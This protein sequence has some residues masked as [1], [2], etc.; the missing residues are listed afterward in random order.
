MVME[1]YGGL[2]ATGSNPP[3]Q[4]EGFLK[5]LLKS[6]S[7]IDLSKTAD[8]FAEIPK[9]LAPLRQFDPEITLPSLRM[10][11]PG[12]FTDSPLKA[13][14]APLRQTGLKGSDLIPFGELALYG[15]Q[16]S[17]TEV[18]LSIGSELL[19]EGVGPALK[20]MALPLIGKKVAK[21]EF[22]IGIGGI[23]L[24]GIKDF[25]KSFIKDPGG[26]AADSLQVIPGSERTVLGS[27]TQTGK[28][29]V[30][31]KQ[32][33]PIEGVG[34][35]GQ[36]S[37]EEAFYGL[38]PYYTDPHIPKI[39]PESYT[40]TYTVYNNSNL[41]QP[42]YNVEVT[43]LWDNSDRMQM[44]KMFEN[45]LKT[46]GS[47]EDLITMNQT[48]FF[49]NYRPMIANFNAI[50]PTSNLSLQG[51]APIDY[52]L[53]DSH[54]AW[55][56]LLGPPSHE[57]GVDIMDIGE[58]IAAQTGASHL[59]GDAGS[60]AKYSVEGVRE[61]KGPSLARVSERRAKTMGTITED[62]VFE[63]PIMQSPLK[64][65]ET[66]LMITF[67]KDFLT[68]PNLT[69]EQTNFLTRLSFD[70]AYQSY[71]HTVKTTDLASTHFYEALRELSR[72]LPEGGFSDDFIK[73][74]DSNW[75]DNYETLPGFVSPFDRNL[76]DNIL[77][78]KVT[79]NTFRQTKPSSVEN[80]NN[81]Y[82]AQQKIL[83][84]YPGSYYDPGDGIIKNANGEPLQIT[85]MD[86][87]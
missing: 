2:R 44:Y 73:L 75:L 83:N 65:E 37:N 54:M 34:P 77:P 48:K 30:T 36:Y 29:F 82:A 62:S 20:M 60:G 23:D 43:E 79:R 64:P 38:D 27:N 13:Q 41:N 17:P 78:S 87:D 55:Q 49:K 69:A 5:N 18:G 1:D 66:D 9:A 6:F 33:T 59:L 26:E 35:G 68:N 53:F 76:I 47:F 58:T 22:N 32:E 51:R 61:L 52:D 42:I 40:K 4:D 74:L 45:W 31:A 12:T 19:P 16:M 11:T 25:N 81:L 14:D 39:K 85:E 72:P 21:S 63:S 46:N 86:W 24:D 50:N 71:G 57:F 7:G 10:P 8:K 15:D 3:P 84:K 70:D 56:Q 67:W 28:F 80:F